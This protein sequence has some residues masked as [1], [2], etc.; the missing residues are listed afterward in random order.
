MREINVKKITEML[1]ILHIKWCF[2]YKVQTDEVRPYSIS[3]NY[4]INEINA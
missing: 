2:C 4:I 3:T 1:I